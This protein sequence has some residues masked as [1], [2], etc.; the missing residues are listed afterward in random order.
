MNNT[1]P[2]AAE[3]RRNTS[4]AALGASAA[5]GYAVSAL[6]DNE[7]RQSL[8]SEKAT[9]VAQVVTDVASKKAAAGST[10]AKV[11]GPTAAAASLVASRVATKAQAK[12]ANSGGGPPNPG[13]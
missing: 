11:L 2:Q 1:R 3:P 9:R 5:A 6:T 4:V 8:R 13:G 10:A 12:K 7:A